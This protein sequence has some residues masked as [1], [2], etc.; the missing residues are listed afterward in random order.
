M[1]ILLFR[2]ESSV[3]EK[4]LE[5]QTKIAALQLQIESGNGDAD[6]EDVGS[7]GHLMS[8]QAAADACKA[9]LEVAVAARLAAVKYVFSPHLLTFHFQT[10]HL[11]NSAFPARIWCTG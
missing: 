11:Q 10:A 2:D 1:T 4:E 8:V 3:S 5:L 6:S 9:D 7:D